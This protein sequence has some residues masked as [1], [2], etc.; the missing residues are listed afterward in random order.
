[1]EI[2]HLAE[3]SLISEGG[4][5]EYQLKKSW[6]RATEVQKTMPKRKYALVRSNYVALG[7]RSAREFST[8]YGLISLDMWRQ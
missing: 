2:N 6:E 3:A 4:P 7:L 1:M 8:L 5:L